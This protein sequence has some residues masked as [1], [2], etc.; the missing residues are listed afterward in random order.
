MTITAQLYEIAIL[1]VALAFVVLVAVIIPTLL[2]L[3]RT[4]KAAED[5][6]LEGKKTVEEVNFIL[7]RAAE[8]V[9]DIGELT[10]SVKDVGL[11]VTGLADLV[12]DNVKS[13]I[14]NVISFIFGVEEGF[15][16]F[17]QRKKGGD[18]DG[19]QEG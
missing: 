6:A 10:R 15:K 19:K 5:L 13:P 2:Q 8:Q 14:I 9:D 17:F 4:I 18:G 1:I 3:K 16:R 11:K 12:L 7:K